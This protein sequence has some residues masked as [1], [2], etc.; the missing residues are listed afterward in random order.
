M[1]GLTGLPPALGFGVGRHLGHV[2]FKI[3]PN[4]FKV[5]ET[6]VGCGGSHFG[7]KKSGFKSV[8]VNDIWEDAINTL[9]QNDNDL[10]PNEVICDDIYNINLETLNEKN[11]DISNID[12]FIGGFVCKGFSLAGVRNPYD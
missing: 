10:K 5:A 4:V 2:G 6:F 12:V 3:L 7:F 9:K 8:F 11:I 1:T